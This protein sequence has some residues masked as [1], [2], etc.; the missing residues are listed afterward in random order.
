MSCNFLFNLTAYRS[1]KVWKSIITFELSGKIELQIKYE[2]LNLLQV[3]RLLNT[4][5]SKIE[6]IT[7][8]GILT[9]TIEEKHIELSYTLTEL[10]YADLLTVSR[11]MDTY[12]FYELVQI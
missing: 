4:Y 6:K 11:T 9:E 3:Q 2:E 8:R 10:T 7:H 5:N 1:K 12:L